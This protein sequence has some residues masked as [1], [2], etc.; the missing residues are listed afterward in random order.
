MAIPVFVPPRLAPQG[1]RSPAGVQGNTRTPTVLG[2]GAAA[3]GRQREVAALLV[4]TLAVFLAMALASY[5]APNWMGPVGEVFAGWLA[6]LV[7]LVAWA[8]PLELFLL[9][10]PLVRGKESAA[11]PGRIAGDLLMAVV[12]AALVQ[13]GSPER[14]AFGSGPAGGLIGELFGELARSLFSTAGSFLVGFACLGLILIG[15]AA[16]SFIALAR[17]VARIATR[18]ATWTTASSKAIR[19]AWR[20]AR[21]LDRERRDIERLAKEPHIDT[22]P[23]DEAIV[24][25]VPLELDEGVADALVA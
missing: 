8:L 4:W 11:T 6:S 2:R 21:T 18:V 23:R 22:S 7:G 12:A 13:V 9:G 24:A 1:T 14:T 25:A 15:R 10:I 17:L 5:P 16:F 20:Q 19:E 3:F